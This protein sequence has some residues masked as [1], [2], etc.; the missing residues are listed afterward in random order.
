MPGTATD[1]QHESQETHRGEKT[2][3]GHG[4]APE[5][6]LHRHSQRNRDNRYN[7]LVPK[8]GT[9]PR[10]DRA[11]VNSVGGPTGFSQSGWSAKK[12][13]HIWRMS[14]SEYSAQKPASSAGPL[15]SWEGSW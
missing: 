6:R 7:D 13:C 4:R 11:Q 2:R 9:D 14:K 15:Q 5:S 1:T 12:S 3:P 8:W 10:P